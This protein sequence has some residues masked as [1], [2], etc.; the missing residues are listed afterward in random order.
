MNVKK[1]GENAELIW[2]DRKR[3]FGMPISFTRYYLIKN[4]EDWFKLFS[5]VGL[6]STMVDEINLYRI[7]DISM[8]QSLFDKIFGTG[9][10]SVYS[11]DSRTP[12]YTLL[13]VKNPYRIREML[14]NYVEEQRSIKGVRIAEFQ[15]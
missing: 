10:I 3:Y 9:T 11:N 8:H 13:H 12:V 14:S 15:T 7:K 6:L 4:G 2:K 5:S 1:Y